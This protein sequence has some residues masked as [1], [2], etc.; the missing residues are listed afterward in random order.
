MGV[1]RSFPAELH[2]FLDSAGAT[3][4]YRLYSIFPDVAHPAAQVAM[5]CLACEP[6]PEAY[7]LNMAGD[8]Q[9]HALHE[10]RLRVLKALR[11]RPLG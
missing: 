5:V 11:P 3:G 10:A 4:D 9:V 7:A 2:A 6:V 1:F 8:D